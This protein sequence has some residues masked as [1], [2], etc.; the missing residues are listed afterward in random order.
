MAGKLHPVLRIAVDDGIELRPWRLEDAELLY[1]T[2]GANREQLEEWLPW[3][4]TMQSASDE[5]AFIRTTLGWLATGEGLGCAI[6][7]DRGLAGGIMLN[8]IDQINKSTELGYWLA[9]RFVG[10]GVMTRST[11]ALT[12]FAFEELGLHRVVI[13]AVAGNARSRAI[14]MRLG[15]THEGTER[16]SNVLNGEFI[17]LET[18]SMLSTEWVP[19]ALS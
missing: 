3:P 6:V 7:V 5:A 2:V 12:S 9:E 16:E 8:K 18:Y 11:Q 15:F 14:P 17:N 10:R 13:R 19:L 4:S 1:V